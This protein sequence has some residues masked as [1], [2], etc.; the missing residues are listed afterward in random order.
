MLLLDG[1]SGGLRESE[2]ESRAMDSGLVEAVTALQKIHSW[3]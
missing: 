2:V 3:P 1:D